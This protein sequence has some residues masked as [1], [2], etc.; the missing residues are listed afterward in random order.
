MNEKTEMLHK[1]C[2]ALTEELDEYSKKIEKIWRPWT[3]S[4]TP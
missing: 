3:S 1:L 2:K 4:P